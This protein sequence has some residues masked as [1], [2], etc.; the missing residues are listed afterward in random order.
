LSR[1]HE[2][3]RSA[4]E[5]HRAVPASA[6]VGASHVMMPALFVGASRAAALLARRGGASAN[7]II[8][9][10]PG[11]PEPIYIAG[12][13]VE[14]LYPVGGIVEGFGFT[15]IVFSY[16]G[17][18]DLGFVVD[19]DSPADPWRLA[20]AFERSQRE[21]LALTPRQKARSLRRPVGSAEQ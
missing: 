20:A 7:L 17:G 8:S 11:P 12:S 4:K 16:A 2:V 1:T 5:R 6:M 10:V 3:L 21:L 15:T 18:L 19:R 13:P 14:A 9:N